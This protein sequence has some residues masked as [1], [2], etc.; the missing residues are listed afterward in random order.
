M[1]PLDPAIKDIPIHN[2]YIPVANTI[3]KKPDLRKGADEEFGFQHFNYEK[4]PELT[5][6]RFGPLD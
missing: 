5:R 3:L 2:T 4:D 1:G 6:Q